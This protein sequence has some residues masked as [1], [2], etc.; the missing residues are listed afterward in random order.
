MFHRSPSNYP[1]PL[2][3]LVISMEHSPP[4]CF[5]T[6]KLGVGKHFHD[7]GSCLN[8]TAGELWKG[9][10][11]ASRVVDVKIDMEGF[12]SESATGYWVRIGWFL[13][14]FCRAYSL[15]LVTKWYLPVLRI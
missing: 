4:I 15:S 5:L 12:N 9:T 1:S 14:T 11:D 2:P 7:S 10:R 3:H 13:L 6:S 8:V